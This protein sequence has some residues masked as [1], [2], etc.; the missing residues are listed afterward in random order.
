MYLEKA[1]G[2]FIRSRA[3]WIEEGENNSSYFFSLEK[4]RQ[5]KKSI[6]KLNINDTIVVDQDQEYEYIKAFYSNLYKSFFS[7][8]DCCFFLDQ[9]QG[10]KNYETWSHHSYPQT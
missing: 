7:K 4:Q 6:R 8:E 10:F 5:T 1:K 3:R 9:I 2:A